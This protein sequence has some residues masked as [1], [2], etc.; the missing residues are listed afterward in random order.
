MTRRRR[1]RRS[2]NRTAR[3]ISACNHEAV[4]STDR[5]TL[6]LF[7]PRGGHGLDAGD[8]EAAL[9]RPCGVEAAALEGDLV[10]PHAATAPAR[11]VAGWWRG[12]TGVPAPRRDPRR[13]QISLRVVSTCLAK[14]GEPTHILGLHDDP[15]TPLNIA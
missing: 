12:T 2:S 13:D 8:L 5:K 15:Q 4:R 10:E 3:S 14:N 11:H 9:N 6:V 7:Q 1:R